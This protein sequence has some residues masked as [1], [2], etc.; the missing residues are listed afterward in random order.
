MLKQLG[1]DAPGTDIDDTIKWVLV[2]LHLRRTE[3]RLFF[4]WKARGQNPEYQRAR[5]LFRRIDRLRKA[6]LRYRGAA[7]VW[8]AALLFQEK[9]MD[10]DMAERALSR[11]RAEELSHE[12]DDTRADRDRWKTKFEEQKRNAE[13][14]FDRGANRPV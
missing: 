12:L 11:R 6:A 7:R 3:P 5:A 14:L 8:R 9:S 2:E 1:Y 10:E 13:D 4:D